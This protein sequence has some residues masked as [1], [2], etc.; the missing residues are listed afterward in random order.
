VTA[1]LTIESYVFEFFIMPKFDIF[2]ATLWATIRSKT[3]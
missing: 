2:A 3:G 1:L